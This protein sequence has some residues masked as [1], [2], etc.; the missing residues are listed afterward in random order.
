M[1]YA[2]AMRWQ[3][4]HPR[5]GKPQYMGF[6][7]GYRKPAE[8]QRVFLKLTVPNGTW[9]PIQEC[10]VAEAFAAHPDAVRFARVGLYNEFRC[11]GPAHKSDSRAL[12]GDS[13]QNAAITLR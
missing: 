11:N 10:T 9:L 1:S 6:D 3:K 7:T 13:G 8:A 12:V 2:Q 4:K 5:G